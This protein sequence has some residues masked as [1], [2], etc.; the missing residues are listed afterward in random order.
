MG[1]LYGE[2][3]KEKIPAWLRRIAMKNRHAFALFSI[4]LFGKSAIA[5]DRSVIT[6]VILY[7][8]AATIER[9]MQ[10]AARA[11]RTEVAGLPANFDPQSVRVEA[12]AGIQVGEVSVHD[13]GRAQAI[14]GRET[15]I[16][17]KIQALT[18]QKSVLDIDAKS[19]ELVRDY[20]TRLSGMAGEGGNKAPPSTID[21]QSLSAV[22][23]VIGR[24]GR[25][26]FGR[27]QR[28]EVQ[29]RGIDK[30]I[31]VL[32]RDLAK[33]RS[34]A[35]DARSIVIN[36]GASGAGELRV[37]YQV[38]GAGWRPAYRAALDSAS[39][40][41]EFDRQAVVTQTTGEDWSGVK[42]KL[43][44]S[45][46]RLSPQGPEPIPWTVAIRPSRA[47]ASAPASAGARLEA[48]PMGEA[49][50]TLAASVVTE[51]Q[52]T[53][54]TEFDVPGRID[55]PSDG[56]QVTLNLAKQV[57]PVKQ[58][59]RV[60]PRIDTT[61][62]V[63]VET[64]RPEGVWP[65]GSI[66]LYR[67]GDFVGTTQWNPHSSDKF[68]FSFG[69]DDRTRVTVDRVRD[70]S[71]ESGFL[72]NRAEREVAYLFAI[73]SS[74]KSVVDLLILDAA[75]VSTADAVEVQ[76]TFEP[77]PSAAN[78]E[79]KR[80]IHG[81]EQSLQPGATFKVNVGYAITYPKDAAVTGL[82]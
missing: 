16:E 73:S 4:L 30:Q 5:A 72:G 40:R 61:A 9:T 19:A 24:S 77:K 28:V 60:V 48:R 37:S 49:T 58:R 31:Q 38:R 26:A 66:Q 25:D 13:T 79:N 12:D 10:V 21:P 14:G 11:T 71:G 43:S 39:S 65:A 78:W 80:G 8:G 6:S 22:V 70:R 18:D 46:P 47:P 44:T 57:I 68:R 41:V 32:Q 20:L 64:E 35:N 76:T 1:Q 23:E 2:S 54:A 53:F 33:I 59:I 74:H 45:Q 29:K 52:T 67:D 36:F 69:R 50:D 55:V 27:L 51:L 63:T 81:W 17:A 75:P 3:A 7:P 42:M 56:R 82:P 15:E 62:F 34:G